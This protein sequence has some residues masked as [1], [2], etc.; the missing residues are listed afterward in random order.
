MTCWEEAGLVRDDVIAATS[1]CAPNDISITLCWLI[2]KHCWFNVTEKQRTNVCWWRKTEG[3]QCAF[4][5]I[6]LCMNHTVD[7][8]IYIASCCKNARFVQVSVR[9]LE[10]TIDSNTSVLHYICIRSLCDSPFLEICV[11]SDTGIYV[12]L[13]CA[14]NSLLFSSQHKLMLGCCWNAFVCCFT[15][16][17]LTEQ[18]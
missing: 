16:R 11:L 10:D 18:I 17:H 1:N 15:D 6:H 14:Q 8:W 7:G 13:P 5:L 4:A 2:K 12:T 9:L 3:I